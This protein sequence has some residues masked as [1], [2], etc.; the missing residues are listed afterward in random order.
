ML[1]PKGD[2]PE[3]QPFLEAHPELAFL[4]ALP[5]VEPE[6][7]EPLDAADELVALAD[8]MAG[9]ARAVLV[10]WQPLLPKVLARETRVPLNDLNRTAALVQATGVALAAREGEACEEA[11]E[12]MQKALGT[13]RKYTPDS[14]GA[15]HLQ[16]SRYEAPPVEQKAREAP[17]KQDAPASRAFGAGNK[18]TYVSALVFALLI[19]GIGHG[20]RAFLQRPQTTELGLLDY[21]GIVPEV[22]ER[23]VG[24]NGLVLVTV[25]NEW[26]KQPIGDRTNDLLSLLNGTAQEG[27]TRMTIQ[28]EAGSAL[29]RLDER[30]SVTVLRE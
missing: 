13:L 20:V 7:I 1:G 17:K 3:L 29:M 23:T 25:R 9:Y 16:A 19:A 8:A 4:A 28:N 24:V 15:R 14:G 11:L 21:Q 18:S 30:G 6:H 27:W 22:V 10:Y 2:R 5:K 12:R 26:Q